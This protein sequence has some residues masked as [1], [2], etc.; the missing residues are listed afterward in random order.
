MA[1]AIA[2]VQVVNVARRLNATARRMPGAVGI[3]EPCGWRPDGRRDYR[4]LTF[5]ELDEDSD[6]LASGLVQVGATP[7]TRLAMFV[8]PSIDF[9]SLVFATLKAGVV[10]ILIDPRMG[11]RATLDCLDEVKPDGFVAVPLVHALRAVPGG[12]FLGSRIN[13][14]V[15]RRWWWGGETIA[16]LRR[17]GQTPFDPIA[18]A[19][20]DP[21]AIIFTSGSTG[22]AK[23]VLYR[24]GNFERQVAEIQEFYGIQSGE[25]DVPCFPL[26]GLFNAAMGVTTV[27]PDIDASRP[28]RVDPKRLI[29]AIQDWQATQSYGSP[30]VWDRVGRDCE[31]RGIKL[32]S[33]RRVLSAGA[34]VRVDVLRRMQNCIHPAGEM[35]TPY[36]ATEALPVASIGAN[37]VLNETSRRTDAGSGVCVGRRFPGIEWR[38]IQI[39]DGPIH[40][41][42][43][44]VEMREGELG[45]LIVRGAVVTDRYVTRV[46]ANA[47]AKIADSDSIWHRMGDVGYLDPQG[48]FWFCG[49]LTQRVVTPAGAMYTI[50][51]EAIFN[52]HPELRRSALVGVGPPGEQQPVI[53]VELQSGRVPRGAARAKTIDELRSLALSSPLTADI[54]HFL[55]HP[56]LPVDLRHNVKIN[57][58]KLAGWAARRI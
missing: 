16:G 25:I 45:E 32:S 48:R 24:H 51:C 38:V 55:V 53:V 46:E 52:R 36:G 49:R 1:T 35:H 22:P 7:G 40:S 11:P 20:E 8:P 26:F 37:E 42:A 27:I 10:P 50:P 2:P 3:A 23:G 30:A 6:R 29:G 44:G 47:L 33:L 14:T 19:A 43:E 56:S 12:R 5:R 18:T 4:Q 39:V 28:A 57:R 41:I 31:Q 13:V 58:E 17:R 34:P 21:A 15:G 54:R 9:V